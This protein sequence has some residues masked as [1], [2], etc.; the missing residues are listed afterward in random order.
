M[1][2]AGVDDPADTEVDAAAEPGPRLIRLEDDKGRSLS[3]RLSHRLHRLSWRTPIHAFRLR[4]R[5]PLQLL[6]V[7]QDPIRGDA[8][9][10]RMILAGKL[11][12]HG[13]TLDLATLDL[14]AAALSP[15][16]ADHVQSFAWLRDLSAAA[17]HVEAGPVAQTVLRKWLAAHARQVTEAAWRPDLWGRRILFW[18][19]HAPLIL[20]SD[21]AAYRAAVLNA[22]AR[23]ARHLDRCA[24]KA[25]QGLPRITAWAGVIA[26]GLL[27]SGGESRVQKGE[28]GLTQAL[29]LSLYE[30]GGLASRSPVSQLELVELLGQLRAVYAVSGRSMPEPVDR[31]LAA[32]V[33]ALLGVTLGDDSL[34]CWQGGGPVPCA[35]RE[36]GVIS[37][38]TRAAPGWCSTPPRPR[39]AASPPAAAPPLS[40]SNCRTAR[41]GSSSIAAARAPA[42]V[43]RPNSPPRCAPPPR[44][45]R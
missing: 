33:P 35:R 10:G 31:A 22:L 44:T 8:A 43:C 42:S 13:Q 28:E 41:N 24:A 1:N 15:E 27:I 25:H 34:S 29:A 23:G 4:G 20:S 14:T 17:T 38:W 3:E 32:A 16:L 19:A 2:Q 21:D 6:G 7:P 12:H 45:A 39:S 30:D 5:H 11:V 37:G 40:P 36:T 26:A 9:H 18:T